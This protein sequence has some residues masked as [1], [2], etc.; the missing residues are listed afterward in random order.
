[1]ALPT[2]L[3]EDGLLEVADAEV[4]GVALMASEAQLALSQKLLFAC[5]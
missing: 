5:H 2:D 1:V 3:A 4:S